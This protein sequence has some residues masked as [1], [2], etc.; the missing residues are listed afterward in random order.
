MFGREYMKREYMK[1]GCKMLITILTISIILTSSGCINES[2]ERNT[3]SYDNI[4]QNIGNGTEQIQDIVNIL[5]TNQ[6]ST[7]QDN[8]FIKIVEE[9]NNISKI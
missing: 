4:T 9:A 8:K 5:V 7:Y 1:N 3:I 6:S 2:K